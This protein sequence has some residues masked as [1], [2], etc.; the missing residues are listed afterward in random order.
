MRHGKRSKLKVA[1]VD[2]ALRARNL[3]VRFVSSDAG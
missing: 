3:E 2:Y 1:D